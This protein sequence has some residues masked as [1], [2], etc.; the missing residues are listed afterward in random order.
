MIQP[1]QSA[2]HRGAFR[3]AGAGFGSLFAGAFLAGQLRSP[4]PVVALFAAGYLLFA[5][6]IHRALVLWNIDPPIRRKHGMHREVS[7]AHADL[8]STLRSFRAGQLDPK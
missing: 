4:V 7:S 1:S 6:F 5:F 3:N 2:D 8:A